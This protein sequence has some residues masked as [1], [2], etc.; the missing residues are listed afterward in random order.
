MKEKLQEIKKWIDT[1][2]FKNLT[3]EEKG[4]DNSNQHTFYAIRRCIV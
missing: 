3:S 2:N 4:I 1:Q